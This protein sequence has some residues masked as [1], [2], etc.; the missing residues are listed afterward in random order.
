MEG[1]DELTYEQP[2]NRDRRLMYFDEGYGGKVLVDAGRAE[3]WYFRISEALFNA[4][5][6]V[7]GFSDCRTPPNWKLPL[8][9]TSVNSISGIQPMFG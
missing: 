7:I 5:T 2:I 3:E 9:P 8:E 6:K 1:C 4:G